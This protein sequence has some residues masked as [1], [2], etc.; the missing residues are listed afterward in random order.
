MVDITITYK[1]KAMFTWI[2]VYHQYL[3]AVVVVVVVV[4]NA[5]AVAPVHS[6]AADSYVD[7]ADNSADFSDS[8]GVV[9]VDSSAADYIAVAAVGETG[10][11]LNCS[12]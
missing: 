2:L 12:W 1:I 4:D 3:P 8:S 5:D 7:F 6:S 9:V 11:G 10:F